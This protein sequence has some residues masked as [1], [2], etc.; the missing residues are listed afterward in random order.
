MN[1]A[2][3]STLVERAFDYRGHVTISRRDGSQVIGFVYDRGPAH[4]ELFDQHAVTRIRLALEDIEDIAWT[5]EDFAEK[6]QQM[7]ERRRGA[8]EPRTTPASGDWTDRPTLV[9]VALPLEL[10]AVARALGTEARGDTARGWLGADHV[11]ARATGV[12]SGAARVIAAD[13]PRLV[14]SCGLAGALEPSLA[15]GDLVVASAVRDECG[16]SIPAS[17]TIVRAARDALAITGRAVEGELV[18]ATRVAATLD[19]KR[20]LAR[21]GRLAVDVES[22]PC[23]RAAQRA[24][25]PWLALRVVVDPFH[26]DLP[27]FTREVRASYTG[28]A[29]RHALSGPRAALELARLAVRTRTALR[30]LEHALHRLAPALGLLAPAEVNT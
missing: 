21:P 30:S 27:A 26:V 29:V 16:D 7:W 25:I 17:A 14:I 2:R 10:R 6:A 8:L 13:H 12:G 28:A 1:D 3:I 22:W 5:G 4:V 20:A 18:C 24:G 19:D 23:A 9:V 15:T 11:I